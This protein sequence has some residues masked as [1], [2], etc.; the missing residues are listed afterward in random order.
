MADAG[1]WLVWQSSDDEFFGCLN[2]RTKGPR[3]LGSDD[4]YGATIASPFVGARAAR[5]QPVRL[6]LDEVVVYDFRSTD[7][8]DYTSYN[9]HS[10]V[11][12]LQVTNRGS[13]YI[14]EAGAVNIDGQVIGLPELFRLDARGRVTEVDAG[15]IAEGSLTLTPDTRRLYWTK[16]GVARTR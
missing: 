6:R 1:G 10:W 14:L 16:D 5:P 3:F 12:Q 9:A 2:G 8:S 15:A 11:S 13:A 7:E 4:F